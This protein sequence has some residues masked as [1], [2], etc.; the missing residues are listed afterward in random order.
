MSTIYLVGFKGVIIE[1]VDF[2]HPWRVT[3]QV[4]NLK[5]GHLATAACKLTPEF[6][7][8]QKFRSNV[9]QLSSKNQ[10]LHH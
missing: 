9:I 10:S 7:K 6:L 5:I 3:S 2:R 8:A 4:S 1:I